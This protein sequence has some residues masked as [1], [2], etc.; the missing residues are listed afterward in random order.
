MGS[1]THGN[2]SLSSLKSVLPLSFKNLDNLSLIP[3]ASICLRTARAIPVSHSGFLYISM[4]SWGVGVIC[5]VNIP[6]D[7]HQALP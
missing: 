5:N 1:L 6:A 4:G 7:W 2:D 3:E